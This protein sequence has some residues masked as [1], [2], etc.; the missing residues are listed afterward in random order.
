MAVTGDPRRM[1]D[2]SLT[3]T[4]RAPTMPPATVPPQAVPQYQSPADLTGKTFLGHAPTAT[5]YAD[6]TAPDPSQLA[7]DPYY[8]FR[9]AEGQKAIERGAAAHGTLLNGG[10]LKSLERYRQGV[11]SEEAGKNFDRALS[12]YNTNRGTNAQNFGQST[13]QFQGDLGIFNANNQTGLDWARLAQNAPQTPTPT[14]ADVTSVGGGTI[15]SLAMPSGGDYASMVAAQRAQNEAE[16]ARALGPRAR[17][18]MPWESPV[19]RGAGG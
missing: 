4:L 8:Q 12:I 9:T 18:P 6:F 15:G 11:A 16:S 17:T 10:T 3:G 1:L 7:N 13:T 5:P 2:P 14:L 19:Q